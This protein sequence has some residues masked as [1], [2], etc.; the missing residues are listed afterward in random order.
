MS[1]TAITA[2]LIAVWLLCLANFNQAIAQQQQ[3]QQQQPNRYTPPAGP[4]ISPYLQYFRQ[5]TGVLN[6][7]NQFVRPRQELRSTLQNQN[8]QLRQLDDNVR[9]ARRDI[10]TLSQTRGAGVRP[11]GVGSA[12][13]N[14]SHYYPALGGR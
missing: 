9:N 7:Y 10:N 13:M 8:Q 1:K 14:F 5:P 6:N 2:T 11:T 12:Y 3:Q 4:T